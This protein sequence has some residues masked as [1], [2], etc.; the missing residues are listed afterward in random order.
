[1]LKAI[2]VEDEQ[3]AINRLRDLLEKHGRPLVQLLGSYQTVEEGASAITALRPDVVFLDVQIGDRTGF[4]LLRQL[5]DIH[6]EIIFTTAYEQYAVQAFRFSAMDYLLKPIDV[7]DLIR[8]IGKLNG[9][10]ARAEMAGQLE[11]LYHNLKR[12]QGVSRRISVPTL[13]GL[14]FL[15]VNEIIR[16]QS[17]VNYTTLHLKD[18]RKITVAKTLKEFEELLLDSHFYRVHNSHLINLRHIKSYQKGKGGSVTMV[19]GSEIEVSTRRKEDF[20]KEIANSS[21]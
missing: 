19:D 7:D 9:K 13:T 6:F 10:M 14:L 12:E 4:D 21:F 3:H 8:T 16:C 18:R 17:D 1:M 15:W 5:K 2:I 20:L 11:T